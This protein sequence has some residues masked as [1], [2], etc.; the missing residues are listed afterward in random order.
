MHKTETHEKVQQDA[1]HGEHADKPLCLP[2]DHPE[3]RLLLGIQFFSVAELEGV[4]V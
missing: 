4:R 3:I 2:R 1:G